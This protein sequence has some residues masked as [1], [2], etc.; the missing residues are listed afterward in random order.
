[1]VTWY[2]SIP[3]PTDLISNSQAQLLTNNTSINTVF[4]DASNG[5]F[6]KVY[7]QNVGTVTVT[8]GDPASVFHALNG[9]GATFNGHPIPYFLNSLG[10]FPLIPDLQV[11]GSNYSFTIG[12]MIV[13]FGSL[14]GA[15]NNST[16][17]FATAFPT[18]TLGVWVSGGLGGGL[19]PVININA[20]SLP[21]PTTGFALKIQPSSAVNVFYL[22]IGN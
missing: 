13:K 4:N 22:A 14:T 3:Q 5:T 21:L 17:T 2:S 8:P 1:M 11:S 10:D 6:S 12:N 15:V 16:I 18:A 7:L 20:S 9:T 19:Q